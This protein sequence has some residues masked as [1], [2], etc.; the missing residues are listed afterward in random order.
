LDKFDALRFFMSGNVDV[1][2][3]G[4]HLIALEDCPIDFCTTAST[5]AS[6]LLD[7]AAERGRR[8]NV[9]KEAT[10]AVPVSASTANDRDGRSPRDPIL[11]DFIGA[12]A[13]GVITHG[14]GTDRVAASTGDNGPGMPRARDD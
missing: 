8:I 4:H 10:L 12:C 7:F 14:A 1:I 3:N 6:H 9:R 5:N 11:N 13:G 2:L